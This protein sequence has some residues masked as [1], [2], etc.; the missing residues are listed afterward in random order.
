[1]LYLLLQFISAVAPLRYK[2]AIP[3]EDNTEA[4]PTTPH[5][6]HARDVWAFAHLILATV[7]KA[8]LDG[9]PCVL[10]WRE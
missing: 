6:P 2:K 7:D 3:P 1:M 4:T 9:M 8:D 5:P 10:R